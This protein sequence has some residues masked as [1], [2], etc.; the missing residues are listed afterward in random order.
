MLNIDAMNH[1]MF[2]YHV[3]LVELLNYLKEQVCCLNNLPLLYVK[4]FK[5]PLNYFKVKK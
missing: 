2:K 4:T 5:S 3:Y 1:M